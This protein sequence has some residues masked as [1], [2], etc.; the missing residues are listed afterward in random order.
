[1]DQAIAQFEEKAGT[2]FAAEV[3][4]VLV[5]AL[6]HGSMRVLKSDGAWRPSANTTLPRR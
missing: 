5:R 4:E 2:Q 6:R 3:V 1:M